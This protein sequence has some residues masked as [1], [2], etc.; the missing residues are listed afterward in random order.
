MAKRGGRGPDLSVQPD[1]CPDLV[2][3]RGPDDTGVGPWVPADKHRLLCE[4]LYA[5]RFAWRKWPERVLIDPFCGPG[6]VK[7]R[8]EVTTREGGTILAC[9]ALADTAPFTR[10]LIGDVDGDRV[11]ACAARLRA[12]QVPVQSFEGPAA[13]TIGRMVAAVPAGTLCMAYID[14]YNLQ[15]LSFSIL[16]ALSTLK[17]DLAINFSVMDLTRNADLETDPERA[18]FD[19][20]A[21]GWRDHVAKSDVSKSG[22]PQA[23]FAYWMGLV[24]GLG[25]SHSK[26]MP[27]ITNERG[28]GLYR[29]VFFARHDL[30]RRIWGDVA[31]GPN[32]ELFD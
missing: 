30:P 32:R 9:R 22:L 26:A 25:F 21:P 20:A 31:R 24:S 14:P 19:G 15:Y 2:V 23:L 27:L 12:A 17:V 28:G 1:P 8:G 18:R 6:R 16:E 29:M 7:V 5:S 11:K 13:D 3:E 4:Y 10:V